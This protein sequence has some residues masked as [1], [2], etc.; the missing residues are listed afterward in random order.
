METENKWVVI[1][2]DEDGVFRCHEAEDEEEA[3]YKKDCALRE[4]GG[5]IKCTYMPGSVALAA[6]EL[7]KALKG[8]LVESHKKLSNKSI[9]LCLCNANVE[10]KTGYVG[11]VSHVDIVMGKG[12]CVYCKA[13]AAVKSVE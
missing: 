4:T 2:R 5:K 7:L 8:L 1:Y 6:P 3:K 13:R 12:T 9:K 10:A 11:G